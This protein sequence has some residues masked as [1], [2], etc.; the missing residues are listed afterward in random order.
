MT[1][2][3]TP[4]FDF[5]KVISALTTPLTTLTPTPSLVKTSLKSLLHLGQIVITFRTLHVGSF[6][7][8]RPST[9]GYP[10]KYMGRSLSKV[11]LD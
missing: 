7:T 3:T 2:L 1:P 8:F 4:I 10:K 5:H 11:N 9:R 6:I